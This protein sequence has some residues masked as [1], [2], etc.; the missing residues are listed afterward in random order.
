MA[1]DPAVPP[2]AARG[3]ARG[4]S[5][6]RAPLAWWGALP[7][8][9]K[10]PLYMLLVTVLL[11]V[12]HAIIRAMSASLH[13]FEVAFFRSFF[14]LLV[15]LPVLLRH[16]PGVLRTSK[17]H[18]HVMRGSV[19]VV[20]MLMF[21]FA[22][23]ILP[24]AKVSALS[25]TSPLFASL[26]AIVLLRER[27]RLRRT[28]ALL[29]GFGGTLVIAWPG[30]VGI[31]TGTLLVLG[32]SALWAFALITV[33]RL[34]AWDSSI[35][36]VIYMNLMLTVLSFVPAV[37]VWQWPTAGEF[38]WLFGIGAIASAAHFCMTQALRHADTSAVMPYEY[39]RLIWASVLGF[40]LFAEVP[41]ALTIVGGLLIAGSAIYIALREAQM[42]KVETPVL[43][44]VS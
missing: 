14:G 34:S 3:I 9:I 37:L 44:P 22:L 12:M 36:I 24:L 21:F 1:A 27:V 29:T 13:P 35:T 33:K 39:T 17:L 41:S 23:S 7:S 18:L 5:L 30:S 42:R 40:I 15:L 10:A 20:A 25:F 6:L 31:E 19:Q 16:G 43:P 2:R 26:F 28:L 8:A 11:A 38:V 4:P 32:S